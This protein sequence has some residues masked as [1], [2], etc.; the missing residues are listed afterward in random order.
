[1][2]EKRASRSDA[3]SRAEHLW[4]LA[5]YSRAENMLRKL[6]DNDEY[7]VM[8]RARILSR[9]A[10][11]HEA[12][13][14]I[15]RYCDTRGDS[16]LACAIAATAAAQSDTVDV[17]NSWVG[18]VGDFSHCEPAIAAEVAFYIA[19]AFWFVGEH[20]RA[21]EIAPLSF[22]SGSPNAMLRARILR[23]ALHGSANEYREQA[24]ILS[25]AISEAQDHDVEVFLLGHALYALCALAREMPSVTNIDEVYAWYNAVRWPAQSLMS[26][27]QA[28]R[29]IG[30]RYAL[31][32]NYV[33]AYRLL[34]RAESH[35][36]TQACVLHSSLDRV[37]FCRWAGDRTFADAELA[38]ALEVA[39][40]LDV[41]TVCGEER[42]ALYLLAYLLAPNDPEAA[43]HWMECYDQ[44]QDRTDR[45]SSFSHDQRGTAMADFARGIV[46]AYRG[47]PREAEAALKRAFEVF[48]AIGYDWRAL[49]AAYALHDVTGDEKWQRAGK[50]L[51]GTFPRSYV[52]KSAHKQSA[53][54]DDPRFASLTPTQRK[55]FALICEGADL[56]AIAD[57]LSIKWVTARNHKDAILQKFDETS[58]RRLIAVARH[59]NLI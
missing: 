58:Q 44:T 13:A 39:Q 34:R 56:K 22:F 50:K 48:T 16:P 33:A 38:D 18:R 28:T 26:R 24:Q 1:M 46:H 36:P 8:L 37:Q 7:S 21:C 30:W 4:V 35:A 55:V 25:L 11:A 15:S 12:V 45:L 19:Q 14:I 53:A 31:D 47:A 52:E 32:G 49:R 43:V 3:F 51:L 41:A 5:E 17:V 59:A 23:G 27:F 29:T 54:Y 9:S 6:P 40:K 57:R 20:D 10:R 42:P 2:K